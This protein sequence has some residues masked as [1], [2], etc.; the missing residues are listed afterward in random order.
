MRWRMRSK[1]I[2]RNEWQLYVLAGLFLAVE[3]F[4]LGKYG[5]RSSWDTTEYVLNAH[6]LLQGEGV[7]PFYLPYVGYV[8]YLALHFLFGGNEWSIVLGQIGVAGISVWAFYRLC[9]KEMAPGFAFCAS[10]FYAVWP[11]LRYWDAYLYTDS[12]YVSLMVIS[13]YCI[14]SENK[15]GAFKIGQAVLLGAVLLIRPSAWLFLVALLGARWIKTGTQKGFGT[16]ESMYWA[17]GLGIASACLLFLFFRY[18]ALLLLES[19][20]KG[21]VIYP[22]VCI[23]V[24]GTVEERKDLFSWICRHPAWFVKMAGIK[25]G[26]FLSGIKPFYSSLHN[27]FA[28][29]TNGFLFFFSGVACLKKIFTSEYRGFFLLFCGLH[30]AMVGIMAENWDGRFLLPLLP[31][32]IFF[33][34]GGMQAVFVPRKKIA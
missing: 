25:M 13:L 4:F 15:T 3:S 8:A 5:V 27:A 28:L 12:L 10:M 32:A 34:F 17:S 20:A 30:L 11:S 24:P 19:Y 2:S 29:V 6:Q 18:H 14:A 21:E 7:E 9:Q 26:Y 22:D 16:R 23:P 33:C 31:A 1:A